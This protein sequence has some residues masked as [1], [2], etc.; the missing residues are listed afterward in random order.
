[1]ASQSLHSFSV[2]SSKWVTRFVALPH[3]AAISRTTSSARSSSR[4]PVVVAHCFENAKVSGGDH[5][6][7]SQTSRQEPFGRPPANPTELDE[8]LDCL[9]VAELAEVVQSSGGRRL[10]NADDVLGLPGC[11]LKGPQGRWIDW[12]AR[13]SGVGNSQTVCPNNICGVPNASISRD[14]VVVAQDKLTCWAV[15]DVMSD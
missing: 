7:T 6:G 3:G 12:S 5:V 10:G 2:S 1:M 4:A 14:R 11:E 15:I 9:F 8:A 13:R